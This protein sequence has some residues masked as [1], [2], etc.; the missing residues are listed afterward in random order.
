MEWGQ[1]NVET[2]ESH[3]ASSNCRWDILN[4]QARP[5]I[6]AACRALGYEPPIICTP[7]ELTETCAM[8]QDPVVAETRALREEY[9]RQFDHDADAIF[10]DILRRQSA[11]EAQL[12]FFPPREPVVHQPAPS[13]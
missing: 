7:Y 8:W 12:V 1:I 5:R 11:K 4:A 10:E 6:E 9:A 13:R 3:R 2:K